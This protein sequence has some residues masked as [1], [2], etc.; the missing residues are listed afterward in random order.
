[1]EHSPLGILHDTDLAHA[2]VDRPRQNFA[3]QRRYALERFICA[4]Y[5]YVGVPGW[6]N[7]CFTL[8]LGLR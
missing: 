3:P 1:H 8:L 5:S 7:A 6:W 2:D 4:A